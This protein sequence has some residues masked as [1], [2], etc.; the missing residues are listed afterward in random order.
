MKRLKKILK[1][2]LDLLILAMSLLL[3]GEDEKALNF[4]QKA[5]E[6]DENAAAAYYSA[7]NLFFSNERYEEAKNM[8]RN[9]YEKGTG[10]ER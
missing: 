10:N 5:I 9:G 4:Y 3:L 1:I 8:L 6:I 2:R 7:G